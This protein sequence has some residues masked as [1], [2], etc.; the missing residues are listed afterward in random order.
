MVILG[1]D[2][3]YLMSSFKFN[4]GSD[5]AAY[6]INRVGGSSDLSNIGLFM[7]P[8]T[9]GVFVL[10]IALWFISHKS[11]DEGIGKVS[12]ILIPA[13]FI[14][15]AI[16]I[17]Y[18]LTLPGAGLGI[19]TL[20]NPNWGMLLDINIWLA[21][22]S[23]IIFSL[24]M[25][26]AIALTYATYL[27]KNSKLID[28]VLIVVASNSLFEICTAFGVFSILGYMSV[29]SG[30]PMNELVSEGTSLVFVVFPKI[31]NVMGAAGKILAPLFFLAIL[32]AGITSALG[33]FEPLLS[34]LSVKL[35][36]SRKKTATLLCIVGGTVSLI[37]TNGI[38][39]YLI[40]IIDLFV[41]EL[42]ILLL[43]GIQCIIFAWAYGLKNIL[44]TLNEYSSFKVGKTWMFIIK[45]LL[46][47]VLIIMWVMGV[48]NL[49]LSE[50]TFEIIV[51][52]IIVL[53]VMVSAVILTKR[54]PAGQ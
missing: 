44:P 18:S 8:T 33:F 22:F 15:M 29:T 30:T 38:C 36:L 53:C 11:L 17:C 26:Q 25:G 9:M 47:V 3:V 10:W 23:Q 14:I 27:P 32:F 12:K 46:P 51:D 49:L 50:Q 2:L 34:S 13:L 21:A 24:S 52:V 42:G 6:F 1:W 37:L 43:I 28:N 20:L 4:W 48:F 16:I 7:T 39:S 31:F 45:Y 5:T 54:K 41:N 40:E 35:A 19:S